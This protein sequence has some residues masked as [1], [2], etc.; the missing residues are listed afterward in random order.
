MF[1]H[2]AKEKYQLDDLDFGAEES[3]ES[4]GPTKVIESEFDRIQRERL[5]H[6]FNYH[7]RGPRFNSV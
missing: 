2:E 4:V 7:N 1:G 6:T 3:K 5:P